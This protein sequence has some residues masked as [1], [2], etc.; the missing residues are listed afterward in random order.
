MTWLGDRFIRPAQFY[1]LAILD[2]LVSGTFQREIGFCR[3][4]LGKI[5]LDVS[6]YWYIF[7]LTLFTL[8][9]TQGIVFPE[10]LSEIGAVEYT[11]TPY[12]IFYK[13]Y[14]FIH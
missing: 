11:R 4:Y 13:W 1:L 3:N 5:L 9:T 6:K 10:I 14:L 2:I 7:I 8:L 12:K